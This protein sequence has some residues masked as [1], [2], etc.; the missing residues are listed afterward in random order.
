MKDAYSFDVDQ[1]G[2]DESYDAM[3]QAY[4]NIFSRCGVDTVMVEADSGAIGGKD[5][6][7][8]IL[9][10]DSGEDNI[11]LC[12]KC[13]YAA[14][15]EKAEFRKSVNLAEHPLDLEEVHTPGLKTIEDIAGFLDIP[16]TKTLKAV[17]YVA[18]GEL[19]FVVIPRRPGGQRNQAVQ[20]PRRASGASVRHT[21]RIEGRG[22]RRRIGVAY[23]PGRSYSRGRFDNDRH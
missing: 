22:N 2:L 18:N 16:S 3:V 19:L 21:R 23:R 20:R 6:Q 9:I 11:I 8:F 5:S 17:F 13:G 10:A 1:A 15:A 12:E 7:E 4:K 14:N